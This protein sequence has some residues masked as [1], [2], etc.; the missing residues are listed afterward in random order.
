MVILGFAQDSNFSSS[1][2]AL[3]HVFGPWR[4]WLPGFKGA[5]FL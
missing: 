4:S 2:V 5:E 3:W 1:S